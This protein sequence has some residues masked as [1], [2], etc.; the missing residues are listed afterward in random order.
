MENVG[1]S[2]SQSVLG[3]AVDTP[4]TVP[5][6]LEL[7]F[8]LLL[9]YFFYDLVRGVW[10]FCSQADTRGFGIVLLRLSSL[11]TQVLGALWIT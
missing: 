4:V 1:W 10:T 5:V 8:F 11:V 9:S 7:S 2:F 3:S 6:T